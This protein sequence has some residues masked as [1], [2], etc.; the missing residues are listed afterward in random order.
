MADTSPPARGLVFALARVTIELQS[1][2]TI[3]TGRGDDVHDS[4]CVTDA[5]DLPALPGSSLAG[6]LRSAC[7]RLWQDDRRVNQLFGFQGRSEG[8][9]SRVDVSWGSAHDYTDQP[10]AARMAPA[11]IGKDPVLVAL[12]VGVLRDHVRIGHDGVAEQNGKFDQLLVPAGAR[13]SFELVVRAETTAAATADLDVLLALLAS[14]EVRLGRSTRR[15]H[16][17]FRVVAAHARAFDLRLAS[18]RTALLALPRGLRGGVSG[19]AKW[20]SRGATSGG[21]T[22]VE[23]ELEPQDYWIFGTGTPVRPEHYRQ[24][25][26]GEA[27]PRGRPDERGEARTPIGKVPVTEARIVWDATGKGSVRDE[28]RF[29]V[30]VPAS[31]V[32]GALRHRMLFHAR[33]RS[34]AWAPLPESDATAY[35]EHTD[36]ADKVTA[37][38]VAD[39]KA[40]QRKSLYAKR[41]PEAAEKAVHWLLG[42]VDIG[43]RQETGREAEA[44]SAGRVFL[45][46]LYLSAEEAKS[47]PLQHVSLDRFT[48]GP[49]DGLLYDEAPIA[50]GPTLKMVLMLDLR[51]ACD[52]RDLAVP[53]FHA[54][55]LDLAEGRLALGAGSNR[56][57]GYFRATKASIDSLTKALGGTR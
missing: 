14:G 31:G 36:W 1:S 53:S 49:M 40:E 43:A 21:L 11:D 9:T 20:Q 27:S 8:M 12:R 6:V 30:L 38:P 44:A 47:S 17:A 22:R 29:D 37:T 52:E 51:K 55:L 46:D 45:A 13:F 10:V 7:A 33:R 42:N 35:F 24:E 18:D 26:R 5:N 48:M 57:H 25:D 4:T 34:G 28:A 32:K 50:K 16:G 23:L 2:L 56:G 39:G 19:L 3:G 41:P 15:G 54:A